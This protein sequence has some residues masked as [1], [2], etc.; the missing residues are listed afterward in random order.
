MPAKLIKADPVTDLA[1]IKAEGISDADPDRLRQLGR[2]GWADGRTRSAP[3]SACPALSPQASSAPCTARCSPT[4]GD[5]GRRGSVIDGIQTDAP[6]N[7]GNSGGALVDPNGNLVG[8]TSASPRWA[9]A[10]SPARSV[11]ASRSR[12]TRPRSSP[13]SSRRANGRARPARGAGHRLRLGD[14]AGARPPEAHCERC[15]GH[16]GLSLLLQLQQLGVIGPPHLRHPVVGSAMVI[17]A[18][19]VARPVPAQRPSGHRSSLE[20]DAKIR[21]E[22]AGVSGAGRPPGSGRSRGRRGRPG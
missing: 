21:R 11:S 1:V 15:G 13:S 14:A 6:I 5:A 4:E 22:W 20:P 17:D 2:P 8:I 9:A 10:A 12:S 3:R 18:V 7:P 19:E 16:G